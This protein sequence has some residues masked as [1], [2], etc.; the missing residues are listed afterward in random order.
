MS[1]GLTSTGFDVNTLAQNILEYQTGLQNAYNNPSLSI[2]DNERLGHLMKLIADRE[3]KVWQAIQQVYQGWT[4]N[5]AESIFLDEIFAL[6]GV[7]RNGATAGVGDAVIEVDNTSLD[8]TE[9]I[10]GTIFNATN[11]IQYATSS[12]TLV[13]TRVTAYKVDASSA[14]LATYNLTITNNDTDEV[15]SSSHT[16]SSSSTSARLNFLNSIRTALLLVNPD[17]DNLY[18]DQDNLVLYWG[19]DEAYE[20]KGLTQDVELLST[21]TLGNR[22]ALVEATAVTAGFYPLVVGGISTVS[23]LP[24]GYVSVTNLTAFSDG[25]NIETDAAFIERARTVTDSPRSSTRAAI[26]AGLLTN[27]TGIQRAIIEKVITD[28]I[29]S[30][31]PIIIGGE[32]ASI[33]QELYRTQPINNQYSGTESYQVDTEDE[34]VET[35]RFS[36][37]SS[38]QMSIRVTYSTVNGTALTDNEITNAKANLLDTSESWALGTAIFNF[39]LLSSV[40]QATTSNRFSSLLVEMKRLEDPDSSYSSATYNPATTELPDLVEDNITFVRVL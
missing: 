27:V 15:F 20:L 40:S 21:P 4:L 38:Q 26:I 25:T 5:G 34:G 3:T 29:V 37:G 9:I 8:S 30:V 31:T 22:Y 12:S 35:I 19:F 2:E 17:E 14:S 10:A 24:T 13:S 39:S 28:G 16:L 7:F 6:N 1:N 36:R 18:I 32:T 11:G 23:P 33:A